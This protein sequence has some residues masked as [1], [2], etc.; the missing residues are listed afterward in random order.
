MIYALRR[1][2][3]KDENH[4]NAIAVIHST[5]SRV[6]AYSVS[7]NSHSFAVQT[8]VNTSINISIN[9]STSISNDYCCSFLYMERIGHVA[10]GH[11]GEGYRPCIEQQ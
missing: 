10:M 7:F 3:H 2:D 5:D 8:V 6:V 1:A 11:D 9:T 4:A